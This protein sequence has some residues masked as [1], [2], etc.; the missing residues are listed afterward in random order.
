MARRP[1]GQPR[2]R[3]EHSTGRR[4]PQV[5][6]CDYSRSVPAG[7][8]VLGPDCLPRLRP[9]LS[10]ERPVFVQ[11]AGRLRRGLASIR[12]LI[13]KDIPAL[14][15][16]R[17]LLAQQG[18]MTSIPRTTAS[19]QTPTKWSSDRSR[20]RI[21]I[22]SKGHSSFVLSRPCVRW[23]RSSFLPPFRLPDGP[24]LKSVGRSRYR[25][26]PTHPELPPSAIGKRSKSLAK[27][28]CAT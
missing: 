8:V 1:Y 21:A 2:S 20:K 5:E 22:D 16:G 11:S 14:F 15:S 18:R 4:Y 17:P 19:S 24:P 7:T 13:L 6:T 26:G 28:W 12:P 25:H 10:P 9:S 27:S 3:L 23:F